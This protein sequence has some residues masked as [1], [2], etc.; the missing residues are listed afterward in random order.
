MMEWLRKFLSGRYFRA[1][2]LSISLLV[3][4]I[5]LGIAGLA[6][7]IPLL[8][9][10]SDVLFIVFIF[11]NYSRNIE[12]RAAE[13]AKFVRV[14][15][16]FFRKAAEPFKGLYHRIRD[17]KTHVYLKCPSCKQTLRLPKGRGKLKVSCP[18]CKT[19]FY[20]TT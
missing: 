1:D 12:R 6:A 14:F 20:K 17:R 9:Y 19:E 8:Y 10:I 5:I 7:K 3:L 4:M 18:K 16:P 13:N 2:E 15:G 11:R